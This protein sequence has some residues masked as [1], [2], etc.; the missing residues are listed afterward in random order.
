LSPSISF[1]DKRKAKGGG[2]VEARM[3]RNK[4]GR[5]EEERRGREEKKRYAAFFT[6]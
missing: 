6:L 2:S 5:K 4:K 1:E 3:E